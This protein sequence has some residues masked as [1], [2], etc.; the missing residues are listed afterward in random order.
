MFKITEFGQDE[1]HISAHF[2]GGVEQRT[3]VQIPD[4]RVR[5]LFIRLA[6][7]SLKD[8]DYGLTEDNRTL[9]Q[10]VQDVLT[11]CKGYVH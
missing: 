9:E 1:V 5:S 4:S 3:S 10:V 11:E 6:R 7:S 2:A 8:L